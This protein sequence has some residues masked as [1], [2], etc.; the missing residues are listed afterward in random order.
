[1]K[2]TSSKVAHTAHTTFIRMLNN[3]VGDGDGEAAG[4]PGDTTEVVQ[5]YL[6]LVFFF[7]Q[8]I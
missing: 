5:P 1:M 7:M 3:V 8:A 6:F 4:G 2:T